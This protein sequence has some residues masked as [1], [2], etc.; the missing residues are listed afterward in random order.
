MIQP[1][2]IW[3]LDLLIVCAGTR[4]VDTTAFNEQAEPEQY[5]KPD[6]NIPVWNRTHDT[7]LNVRRWATTLNQHATRY[8][9]SREN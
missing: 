6:I 7:L 8:Y 2:N 4:K 9:L 3:N 5:F 1:L